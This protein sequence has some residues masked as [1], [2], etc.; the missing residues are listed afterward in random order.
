LKPVTKED[1]S[2]DFEVVLQQNV[3]IWCY[4]KTE[5][6]QQNHYPHDNKAEGKLF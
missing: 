5:A 6:Q 1:G 4:D 3:S 2:E